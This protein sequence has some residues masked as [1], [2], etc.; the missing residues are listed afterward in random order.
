MRGRVELPVGGRLT[1]LGGRETGEERFF[2]PDFFEGRAGRRCRKSWALL[3]A[4]LHPFP[5]ASH[6]PARPSAACAAPVRPGLLSSSCSVTSPSSPPS[7]HA[8]A[9]QSG[10]RR[11]RRLRSNRRVETSGR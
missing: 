3:A 10:P 8:V 9:Q 11:R 4:G 6:G 7:L 5:C 1:L 2:S